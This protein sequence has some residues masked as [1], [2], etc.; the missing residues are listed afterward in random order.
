MLF[1]RNY[2]SR[3]TRR[4]P[5]RKL[6]LRK[7]IFK[8]KPMPGRYRPSSYKKYIKSKRVSRMMN[9][10]GETIYTALTPQNEVVPTTQVGTTNTFT[11]NYVLGLA[12]PQGW[13]TYSAL[14]G[15]S[16]PIGT[17]Y[18]ERSGAF[19]YLKKCHMTVSIA[20]KPNTD[21]GGSEP[22]SFRLIMFKPK[23]GTRNF[24]T[25]FT[26]DTSLFYNNTGT[27]FGQSSAGV[28]MDD[29]ALQPLNTK[30]YSIYAQK[31]FTLTPPSEN[32][33]TVNSYYK[34]KKV[35]TFNMPFWKKCRY[36]P[37]TGQPI[38]IDFSYGLAIIASTIGNFTQAN[39][40]EVS[41][42]GTV[43]AADA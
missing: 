12:A 31:K 34:S 41:V 20:M 29:L 4:S 39:R 10:Y 28:T 7:K 17:A 36:S 13:D 5:F 33:G 40:W 11:K 14:G 21:A 24:G 1:R 15:M 25:S 16:I 35:M 6:G 19:T 9:S 26:P 43:T 23:V 3:T 22:V 42:R 27:E 18:N 30:R 2:R 37:T 32:E 8:R 38:D